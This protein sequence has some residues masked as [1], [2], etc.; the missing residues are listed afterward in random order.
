MCT[1]RS[2]AMIDSLY[3][4][5]LPL[6][7]RGTMAPGYETLLS[8][9][10]LEFVAELARTFQPDVDLLLARRR[11]RQAR[12][13]AGERPRFLPETAHIRDASWTV[14][15]LPRDLQ[16]RRVEITGPVDCKRI[17]NGLNSGASVFMADFE[18]AHAPTWDNT[19][20]G[21]I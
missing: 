18:D 7:V 6:E 21:Q 4:Q 5:A 17:I 13:E 8:R 2:P 1:E 15:P 16:D 10:A 9:E 12:F 3:S 19:V 11:E 20:Q 14:A